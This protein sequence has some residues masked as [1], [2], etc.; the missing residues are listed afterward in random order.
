MWSVIT[1]YKLKSERYE[2]RKEICL[3]K[4]DEPGIRFRPHTSMIRA[5]DNI[6]NRSCPITW[7]RE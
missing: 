2:I 4:S 5:V 6:T 1:L 7:L 3:Q